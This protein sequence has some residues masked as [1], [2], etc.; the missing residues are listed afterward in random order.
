MKSIFKLKPDEVADKGASF[1]KYKKFLV[2]G[3]RE[4]AKS[5]STPDKAIWFFMDIKNS[6][7]A[8]SAEDKKLG[9]VL[10]VCGNETKWKKYYTE[11]VSDIKRIAWGTCF[12][13]TNA[14]G[15]PEELVLQIA[16]GKARNKDI[17]KKMRV[18][19][20]KMGI[21]ITISRG[22]EAQE[23]PITDNEDSQADEL[24]NLQSDIKDLYA[25]LGKL[26]KPL[27]DKQIPQ[28]EELL[29]ALAKFQTAMN[30]AKDPKVRQQFVPFGNQTI[31]WKGRIQTELTK[32]KTKAAEKA[33]KSEVK[34]AFPQL[35]SKIELLYKND[36]RSGEAWKGNKAEKAVVQKSMELRSAVMQLDKE[37]QKLDTQK[38]QTV[39][40]KMSQVRSWLTPC[41][42]FLKNQP[43]EQLQAANDGALQKAAQMV[44]RLKNGIV[45]LTKRINL[46]DG[47]QSQEVPQ[48][49]Q[50]EKGIEDFRIAL[51]DAP[52]ETQK[53]QVA[54]FEQVKKL[55][56]KLQAELGKTKQNAQKDMP[57]ILEKQRQNLQR[58]EALAQELDIFN[59]KV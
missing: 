14:S 55:R 12:V 5:H 27:T 19:T 56:N 40:D 49:K 17:L 48:A 4:L 42:E 21:T 3:V 8:D 16:K 52:A 11:K 10:W 6:F 58:A 59:L 36:L 53:Q 38:Q 25:E 22:P 7:P 29:Q 32:A 23:D 41:M 45:G 43:K 35:W 18:I 28:A 47:I 31:T 33:M 15:N 26:E 37:F 57:K 50:L 20:K 1:D 2:T 46:N 9:N 39:R 51:K 13:K 30:A 24:E 44:E 54:F 34:G